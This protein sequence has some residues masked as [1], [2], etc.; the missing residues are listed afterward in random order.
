MEAWQIIKL[1]WTKTSFAFDGEFWKFPV[2]D[3][4]WPYP[5]TKVWG[6]AVDDDDNLL[7]VSIAPGPYQDP[8]PRVF[9]PMSG[10]AATVRFWAR[11]GATVMCLTPREDLIEGMLS[12]YSEE[13]QAAGRDFQR[14]E[15]IITGGSLSIASDEVTAKRRAVAMEAWDSMVYGVPPYKLPHPMALDG[16]PEQVI[17][18][19]AG[20]HKRHGLREFLLIDEFP[21]PHGGEVSLEMLELFGTEVLPAFNGAPV[22]SAALSADA[23]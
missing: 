12:V 19:I 2:P 3:T 23:V 20:L 10:R 11:E 1:A 5:H 9:A 4:K 21:A 7:G 13:A 15:G 6:E 22:A 8:Y 18:Q 17:D 14:G 16:T